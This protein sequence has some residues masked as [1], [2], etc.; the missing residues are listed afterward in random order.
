MWSLG[1]EFS[2][3]VLCVAD[4]SDKSICSL[5]W[6]KWIK[7]TEEMLNLS[8][9]Y[10]SQKYSK[11]TAFRLSWQTWGRTIVLFKFWNIL[12][13]PEALPKSRKVAGQRRNVPELS[14]QV[15]DS[16]EV[17]VSRQVADLQN[18]RLSRNSETQSFFFHCSTWRTDVTLCLQGRVPWECSWL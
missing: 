1:G 18:H 11:I 10:F 4:P 8:R 17:A 12:V 3:F 14:R 7:I 6:N 15:A 16:W 13:H 2:C 5:T 9:L